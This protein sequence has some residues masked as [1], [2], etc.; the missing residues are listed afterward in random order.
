MN[1]RVTLKKFPVVIVLSLVLFPSVLFGQQYKPVNISL[2][3]GLAQSSVYEIVQD[4]QGFIWM[5]TQDGLNR[6][7]G[8][9]FKIFRENPFD[10]LTLSSNYITALLVDHNG[11]LW[12]GTQNHGLNLFV[13]GKMMFRHFFSAKSNSV[14]HNNI[15][16]IYEDPSGFL[17]I[18]TVKGFSRVSVSGNDPYNATIQFNNYYKINPTSDKEPELYVYKIY[19]DSKNNIWVGSHNG[20]YRLAFSDTVI[21][22]AE[23]FTKENGSGISANGILSIA[24]DCNGKLWVGTNN[25]LNLFDANTTKFTSFF[26][27]DAGLLKTFKTV[28]I[29]NLYP[30]INGNLWIGTDG[31]GLFELKKE[32]L[33]DTFIS[34]SLQHIHF[35]NERLTTTIHCINE[36]KINPGLMWIGTFAGG[37]YKLVPVL[38]SFYSDH[39]E[40]EGIE[41]PVV[42]CLWKDN[43]GTVWIGTQNGLIRQNR[44]TADIKLFKYDKKPYSVM[45]NSISSVIQDHEGRLWIGSVNGV[46]RIENASSNEPQFISY[47]INAENSKQFINSLYL[48]NKN[49]LYTIF[50]NSIFKYN[51]DKDSFE[52]FLENPDATMSRQPGYSITSLLIDSKNNCWIGSTMGVVIFRKHSGKIFDWTQPE[53]FYHDLKDTNTLRSHNVQSIIEDTRGNIWLATSNGLTRA[54]IISNKIQFTNYSTENKIKNN[55]VYAT[56]EDPQT[57]L[58]WLSTNGGLTRFDPA[59]KT[60]ANFDLNDGLQSNEFN[61]GAYSRANDG[62]IFFGGIQGYTSFYPSQIRLDL[63][64]PKVYIT[65]FEMP[66]KPKSF[67]YDASGNKSINLKYFENSFTV[68][69]IALHY[70]DPIKNQ[71]AYK[72]EGFQQD[73]IYCGNTHKVNFSQLP[74]GEYIFKVMASNNDGYYNQRGDSLT[75]NIKPPF[76]KTVWF[77]LALLAFVAIV[78]WLLHIYRL[79]MKLAQI[80]E[81]ERIRK[82]TAAD[83]HDEL[84]HKLTTISWFSEIL[85][86]KIKP[87]QFELRAYLDKIIETSGSLYLTMKDLLWAM[88]P[89]K[90]SLYHMYLQLKNFGEELFDHTGIEFNANGVNEELKSFDLPL[91]YKRHILLIFKEVMHNSLKHAKPSSTFLDLEKT[92]GSLTLR[93]GDDGKGFDMSN[94]SM[95][96]NGIKNVKR[97]AE[98][99]HADTKLRSTGTGTLFELKLNLN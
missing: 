13:P 85:K 55:T 23:W 12:I 62:E 53:I 37:S 78:L 51:R 16:D 88:D 75:I 1:L 72:L 46:Q 90:D 70:H 94:G 3:E 96:G 60:T 6:Y 83:F 64:Q 47:Y 42:T 25:G 35:G 77:Y 57:G 4:K 17:W 56:V 69:F 29:K 48:D 14:S 91:S 68:D 61:S 66:G 19:S 26:N 41:S 22:K 89:E 79:Q 43:D 36:D 18:S 92:N 74:P 67:I 11:W 99:I 34:R 24:E 65:D 98:I 80:K 52:K 44:K 15:L 97:R 27:L 84:G 95:N 39:L 73:W 38:K 31:G 93:F 63:V 87:E 21:S 49:N 76:F 2:S 7:D 33:N 45:N 28:V 54:N 8:L 50:K 81:V 86:K 32:N 59:G 9:Q 40:Y 20:L 30:D 71:Y 10:T 58:I 82:E 5:A